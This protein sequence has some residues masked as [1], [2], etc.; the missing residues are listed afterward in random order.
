LH[1][2]SQTGVSNGQLSYTNLIDG[3]ATTFFPWNDPQFP[4]GNAQ[5]WITAILSIIFTGPFAGAFGLLAGAG[6][7]EAAYALQPSPGATSFLNQ[8]SL[9]N[10]LAT[11]GKD[12]R[13]TIDGWANTTFAGGK[14]Q[15][16]N[17][18]LYDILRVVP[19]LLETD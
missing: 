16:G 15:A 7:Q 19:V 8:L 14:D 3:I 11:Y 1:L 5:F 12:A 2:F 9:E 10:D 6:V 18:I 4:L 17:T 13:D